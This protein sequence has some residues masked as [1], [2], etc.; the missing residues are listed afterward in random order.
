[1]GIL[2]FLFPKYC[3]ECKKSGKYICDNCLNK[4]AVGNLSKGNFAVFEYQGVIRKAIISLKYKFAFDIADELV[5]ASLLILRNHE[6]Q[7][8]NHESIVLVP[9]P[10][11]RQRENW[12]G[13]NQAEIIAKKVAQKMGWKFMSNLL[14][15]SKNSRPQVGLK[16]DIR[17]Q[18]LSG[19]FSFNS[20]HYSPST[21]HCSL[22][23]FDDVYTTGSTIKEAKKVLNKAGFRNV[24]SLTIARQKL[25][26]KN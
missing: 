22:L 21:V 5:E 9:I 3:L 7:F 16:G 6:S 15:R 26:Y 1:M 17:H 20:S 13:F 18:N 2:D 10:L 19:V 4:V 8:L 11:H 25:K 23:L 24:Y 12:R 14:L